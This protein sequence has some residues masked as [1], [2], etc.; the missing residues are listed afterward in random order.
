[1]NDF[2]CTLH[3]ELARQP[4][5]LFFSPF[6]IAS[7]LAMAAEGARGETALQMGQV[8]QLEAS[9]RRDE[10]QRPYDWAPVH[11]ALGQL[12]QR[13][14]PKSVPASL[15]ADLD[16]ARAAIEAASATMTRH[17]SYSDAWWEAVHQRDE[18]VQAVNRLHK[19]IDPSDF[20][21]ANALWL[22]QAFAPEPAYLEAIARWY[23][24]GGAM[25]VDFQHDPDGAR[26]RIN[27][28]VAAQ[29]NER[30][31]DLL[32]PGAVDEATRL[33]LVNAVYF[34]GEW[35]EPFEAERTR[36]EAFH[37]AGGGHADTPMMRARKTDA[38]RYAAFDADGAPFDTPRQVAFEDARDDE[39][40]YPAHGFQLLE[41][42][43]R[44]GALSMQVV[45]PMDVDGLAQVESRF[46]GANLARWAAALDA[47]DVDVALPKFELETGFELSRTLQA[48]GMRRAFVN[49]LDTG[50][51][52]QFDGIHASEDPR[53][54]LH[55]GLVVHKAF[56]AV[57]EKGTEAAAAT[58]VAMRAATA[59]PVLVDFIPEVRADRPF[60]FLIRENRSG[61]V[62]F[63][64]R[65]AQPG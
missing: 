63:V 7:A 21:S 23:G 62:L 4:G 18:A 54:R 32:A 19:Q 28:W 24:T 36:D 34:L 49:P 60:L 45:V 37:L 17:E 39:R 33:V 12:A 65:Y 53:E 25:P 31:R 38:V 61:T 8:L 30:I 3:R 48:L 51:G 11:A 20:R 35:L 14:A 43:Y 41:L 47:R 2:A 22:E 42:P 40:C 56:V 9:L 15:Q 5:N 16:A 55:I 57:D 59:M 27:D 1:M 13:L 6:S 64:G 52:A 50:G 26:L 29:T 46:T 44:G 58:A 10:A